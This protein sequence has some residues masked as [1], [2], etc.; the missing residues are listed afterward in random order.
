[1]PTVGIPR[2]AVD[3]FVEPLESKGPRGSLLPPTLTL[4][5]L[6]DGFSQLLWVLLHNLGRKGMQGL[7]KTP[8]G[9]GGKLLA[10]THM[11]QKGVAM[12]TKQANSC[13]AEFL[14]KSPS[15]H[16]H[17]KGKE[18]FRKDPTSMT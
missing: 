12:A 5:K 13:E 16:E 4:G 1:M 14:I 7:L 15:R 18:E 6:L 3:P 2:I 9:I 8:F 17:L 10:F 11:T